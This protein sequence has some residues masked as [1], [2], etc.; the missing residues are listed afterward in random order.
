M[1]WAA[2]AAAGFDYIENIGLAVSLWGEPAS[3]WPQIAFAAAV[4]KFAL[5]ALALA[6]AISGLLAPLFGRRA[7]A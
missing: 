2:V 7:L 5:L 4:A 3:P 1:A 6:A